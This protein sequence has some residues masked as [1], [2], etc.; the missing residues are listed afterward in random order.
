M[1]IEPDPPFPT[2]F[3]NPSLSKRGNLHQFFLKRM[4]NELSFL[5]R[6]EH[7][8][9][10]WWKGKAGQIEGTVRQL[11]QMGPGQDD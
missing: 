4:E 3:P 10:Q 5:L 2:L 9:G 1:R 8:L 11:T 6:G 7:K